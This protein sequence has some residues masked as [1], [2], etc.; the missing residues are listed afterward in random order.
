MVCAPY[1]AH[2]F[3]NVSDSNFKAVFVKAPHP[4]NKDSVYVD[5]KPGQAFFDSSTTATV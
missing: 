5:W 3:E 2:Y 4:V 1:E